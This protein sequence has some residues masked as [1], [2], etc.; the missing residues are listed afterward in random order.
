MSNSKEILA[1]RSEVAELR[2]QITALQVN[3]EQDPETSNDSE[4]TT[5][6][7]NMLKAGLIATGAVAGTVLSGTQEALAADP[8]DL[9]KGQVNTTG[10]RTDLRYNGASLLTTNILTVQDS[11][12][13]TSSRRAAIGGF[14]VGTGVH[15]GVYGFTQARDNNDTS[16]GHALI[17]NA[18]FGGRSSLYLVGGGGNPRFDNYSH[19]RGEQRMESGN[20]WLCTA[21]GTP[22]TWRKI[23]GNN[24]AGS[25]HLLNA[26]VR[27][28][29]SRVSQGGTGPLTPSTAETVDMSPAGI[30]IGTTAAL[31][32]LTIVVPP[33]AGF[34]VLWSNGASQPVASSINFA[35]GQVLGN[36]VTTR[37][38]SNRMAQIFSH[39]A[40]EYVVDVIGYYL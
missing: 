31:V 18:T 28:Y 34:A 25:L 6:R 38:D 14:A 33:T 17:G 4:E 8:N 13:G 16:T 12:F 5:S 7:R 3:Q 19:A 26:P 29:D 39:S 20:L 37:V 23:A 36:N 15:N 11:N 30:P 32:N 9:V 35:A 21:S 2:A 22:G 40:T 27:A 10:S 1:L 24:T